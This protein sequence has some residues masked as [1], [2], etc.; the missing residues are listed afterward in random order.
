MKVL[1]AS[2]LSLCVFSAAGAED[3][4][5]A[6][7]RFGFQLLG[8][9]R[10]SLAKTNFFLSPA[11]LGF[12]L[13]MVQNGA[14][15]DTL[16]EMRAALRVEGIPPAALN[17]GN[18]ELLARLSRLDPRIKLEIANSLWLGKE[19]VIKPD[20]I[21]ANKEAYDAEVSNA[22]FKDPAIVNHI[23]DWVS[24]RTHGK[25]TQMVQAPLD[26]LLRL[27]VLN[28]I[29]FKA[30]WA[31]PFA[32]NLTRDLPFTLAGGQAVRHPRMSRTASYRYL[33]QDGFQ[34]VELPYS[35]GSVSMYVFLPK[36]GLDAFLGSL[37][38]ENFEQ[39]IGRMESRRGTLEL[40]RFK[41]ENEYNLKAVLAS[42]GM[43]LAFTARAD[44]SGMSDEPLCISW[45]KQKTYV[46]VNEQGTE[47]AA[48]TG[49]GMRAMAVHVEP[50]PFQ[51]V[52]DRPFFVAIRERQT[53]LIL[54]LGAIFDPR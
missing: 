53:G 14:K 48:V 25:I 2:L 52:V 4:A 7:N 13:S 16:R 37:T 6:Y 47:A 38:A 19:A 26:P 3:V 10:Q 34:A 32:T 12:A 5:R 28:A 36:G 21:A 33:E 27:I 44:F 43:P 24:A 15:G 29:Y 45:V 31:A 17:G 18:K 40:P 49:I 8:Q 11:G 51:M 20:F 9:C 39:W 54:F 42:M 41:L 50:P 22:D 1:W 46:D 30:D 35:D 23:N